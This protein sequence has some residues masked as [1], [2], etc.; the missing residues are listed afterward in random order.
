MKIIS[1]SIASE[2]KEL[3]PQVIQRIF[4]VCKTDTNFPLKNKIKIID[5]E[6]SSLKEKVMRQMKVATRA[7]K[8]R[9]DLMERIE[10]LED[11]NQEI[12][13]RLLSFLGS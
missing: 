8:S 2:T 3:L 11:R 5:G 4:S 13:D 12:K 9:E 7:K 10:D 1:E 6:V